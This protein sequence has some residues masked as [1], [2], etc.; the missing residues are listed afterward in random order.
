[1]KLNVVD[2]GY[3]LRPQE[4]YKNRGTE[5]VSNNFLRDNSSIYPKD[6]VDIT[7]IAKHI[8]QSVNGRQVEL[9][10]SLYKQKVSAEIINE[11]GEKIAI[12]NENLPNELKE[13][14]SPEIFSAFLQKHLC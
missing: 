8:M 3:N 9:T 2:T 12:K 6:K 5:Q 14:S 1:M 13:I 11:N 7:G 4:V 10:Y